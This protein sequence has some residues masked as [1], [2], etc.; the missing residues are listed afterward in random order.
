[1]PVFTAADSQLE[2]RPHLVAT[3]TML[4]SSMVPLDLWH[5]SLVAAAMFEFSI[6][7]EPSTQTFYQDLVSAAQALVDGE[8]DTIANMANISALIWQY[9]PD[10]NWAGFYR[11]ID[12]ELVLGPFQGKTAC[13]RIAI[14]K[15]VCGTAARSGQTQRVAD[16]HAFP[17]HIACDAESRSE[18]VIP[19]IGEGEVVAVL[20]LDSPLPNRFTDADEAGLCALIETIRPALAG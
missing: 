15:G 9:V 14:G 5:A 8:S 6:S 20:D 11:R 4:R 19:I 1:M 16:V 13:I 2:E 7:D 17:G 3:I 10:L 18:L 12:E